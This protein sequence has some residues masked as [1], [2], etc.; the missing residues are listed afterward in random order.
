MFISSNVLI[1]SSIILAWIAYIVAGCFG[2]AFR[3]LFTVREDPDSS[4]I[5]EIFKDNWFEDIDG[6][7]MGV[8]LALV[9][10]LAPLMFYLVIKFGIFAI[11]F[12]LKS[13]LPIIFLKIYD[14]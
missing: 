10:R 6:G 3:G 5:A 9:F 2:R 8:I 4:F 14:N 7:I 1:I 11:K 12:L 13:A